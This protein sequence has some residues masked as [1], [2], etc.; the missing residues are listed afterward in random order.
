MLRR[1]RVGSETSAERTLLNIF[2]SFLLWMQSK[3]PPFK[4]SLFH[5][6][7]LHSQKVSMN[8][9]FE[10]IEAFRLAITLASSRDFRCASG[11]DAAACRTENG[12]SFHS[13]SGWK[14]SDNTDQLPEHWAADIIKMW[15]QSEREKGSL[16]DFRC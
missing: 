3:H 4:G 13:T 1:K 10:C 12:R 16:K 7:S 9:R 6:F 14:T 11:N 8:A 5:D 15:R 2:S